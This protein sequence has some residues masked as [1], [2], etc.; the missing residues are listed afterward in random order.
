VEGGDDVPLRIVDEDGDAV[1]CLDGEQQVGE[2][3][4]ES[5]SA[6][7]GTTVFSGEGL[8]VVADDADDRGMSLLDGDERKAFAGFVIDGLE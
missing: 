7:N 3:G 6:Q 5:I 2:V 4:G 1:G 8:I